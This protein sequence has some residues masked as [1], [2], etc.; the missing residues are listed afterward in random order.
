M[1]TIR[2]TTTALAVLFFMAAGTVQAGPID[3]FDSC[4]NINGDTYEVGVQ[5][6][7]SGLA[8]PGTVV[9]NIDTDA[10]S[11]SQGLGSVVV[12]LSE[13]G[14]FFVSMF[15]D[16]EIDEDTNTFFNEGFGSGGTLGAGQTFEV[17]EPG[18][19][20]GGYAG[21]IFFNFADG[22]LDN[23][24]MQDFLFGLSGD[25]PEDISLALGWDFSLAEG[26]TAIITFLLSDAAPGSGFWLR[27]DDPDSEYEFF[28]S[29]TLEI[30]GGQDEEP[31][32][33]VPEPGTLLLLGAGLLGIGLRRRR[34]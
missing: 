13:V 4:V 14:D 30:Q 24:F 26:E 9:D 25:A 31:P 15:V 18:Y 17:D 23:D 33:T 2:T 11:A 3:T 20:G 28:F 12:T 6:L 21:D 10:T 32:V 34:H 16:W 22:L 7:D 5:C 1:K 8:A 29:S 19:G 27:Q